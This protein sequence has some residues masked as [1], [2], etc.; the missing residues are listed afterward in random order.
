MKYILL[1][2]F[3]SAC[4]SP[5]KNTCTRSFRAVIDMGSGS[6]KMN[7]AEVEICPEGIAIK[8]K[9]DREESRPVSLEF[10][11]TK[12]GEIP[13]AARENALAALKGLREIAVKEAK[14]RGYDAA[15]LAVVGTH[16]LRTAKNQ[17]IFLADLET[18]GFA[19][20]ALTQDE[21]GRAGRSAALGTSLPQNCRS[22]IMVWDVGGGSAQ[23]TTSERAENLEFGSEAF[24][25]EVL[26]LKVP[27][28][29]KCPADS[30]SPNPLGRNFE[31]ARAQAARHAPAWPAAELCVIGIG[32]VHN[33]AVL[34]MVQKNW[35]HVGPCVCKNRPNCLPSKDGYSKE[36]VA[37]LS[38]YLSPKADCDP[39]LTGPYSRTA[40]SNLALVLGFMDRM[41]IKHVYVRP[42]NMGDYFLTDRG[43]KF[44]K[45]RQ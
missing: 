33:K 30:G 7:M 35:R 38:Q 2:A 21:E 6:T 26:K 44:A 23:I 16:A 27:G 36:E 24:R 14:A 29:D 5:P 32:G 41:S 20:R 25:E 4:G 10:V 15:E 18:Q 8:S 1:L 31:K 43:L 42:V 34:A 9:V 28:T 37:C 45:T 19:A 22:N 39:D 3:L 17:T 11:K 12:D 13:L 40:V